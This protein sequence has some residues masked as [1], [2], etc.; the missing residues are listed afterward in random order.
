MGAHIFGDFVQIFVL[1]GPIPI[2]KMV[3]IF[4]YIL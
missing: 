3:H 2:E 4:E 1:K